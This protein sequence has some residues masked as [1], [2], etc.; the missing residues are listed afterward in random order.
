MKDFVDHV[1]GDLE[2]TSQEILAMDDDDVVMKEVDEGIKHVSM[3]TGGVN[4][5]VLGELSASTKNGV[6]NVEDEEKKRRDRVVK[7][8][9]CAVSNVRGGE[10][11]S[12]FPPYNRSF[13]F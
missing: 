13:F 3:D 1:I 6:L 8:G 4:G 10:G 11:C 12:G 7:T 2:L 9:R 5:E